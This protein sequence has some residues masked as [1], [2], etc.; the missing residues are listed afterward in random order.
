[1]IK[2]L[3]EDHDFILLQETWLFNFE[4]EYPLTLDLDICMASKK[5]DDEN[6]IPPTHRPHGFG[7]I[8]II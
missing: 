4:K 1:M 7:G 6:P 3:L 8:A 2:K 5:V